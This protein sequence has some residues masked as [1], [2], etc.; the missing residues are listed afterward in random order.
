MYLDDI[1]IFAETLEE[2]RRITREILTALE[3]YDLKLN[4]EKCEWEKERITFLGHEFQKGQKMMNKEKVEA[5]RNWKEPTNVK[6]IQR[7]LGFANFYRR[8]IKNYSKIVKPL[9]TLTQ[10][11]KRWTWGKEQQE[12]F[13]HL[14]ERFTQ[15]PIL[16]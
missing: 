8:F 14:K 15:E 16:R 3:E 4:P 12:A 6:E 1:L 11:E 5:I 13:N 2:L 9:T 7:F 10:K